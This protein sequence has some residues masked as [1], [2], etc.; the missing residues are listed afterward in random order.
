MGFV[1]DLLGMGG[2]SGTQ[3]R[4][5]PVD[6][7]QGVNQGQINQAYGQTQQGLANQ[8][9]FI[10]ALMG[11]NAVGR[12]GDVFAQQQALASQLGNLASGKGPNPAMAQLAN[13]TGQNV[14][15]QA[16]LAAGQRG[17]N[18]NVGLLARQ[19]G[20]QGANIQQQAV[21]QGAAL[22]AQQQIAA[23]NAL[24]N[25]Q[26]QMGNLATNQAQMQGQALNA[27]NQAS[28]SQ[29]QNLLN[30]LAQYNQTRVGQQNAITAAN[31]GIAG[32]TAQGQ[33]GL[34][35]GVLG[36]VGGFLGLAKGGEVP[37][38]QYMADGGLMMPSAPPPS[39]GN[40]QL[41][42]SGPKSMQGRFLFSSAQAPAP[43]EPEMSVQKG[44]GEMAKSPL[45]QGMS[46]LISTG[47]KIGAN[48]AVPGAGMFLSKGA[49]VPGQAATKGDSLKNDK[50][51]AMLSPKE[52]V[53]PR[54]VTLSKNAPDK[55]KMFV[56]AVL[57]KNGMRKKK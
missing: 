15:N 45:Q 41:D 16:A 9:A 19:I 1:G 10:N 44:M 50:V 56:E 57:A 53:L 7:L 6:V 38:A 43:K 42:V 40:M 33:Q 12:Q 51:P 35:G 31:A 29:Q 46:K 22:G 28:Q 49:M 21:G 39:L 24:A 13:T 30:A 34:L 4:A 8:Q 54:S 55:A 5:S 32:T 2:S 26:A 23:M 27:Y 52:I 20:Q 18:Q 37:E 36:G 17:A 48:A 25:Q 11:Q 3:F 14:A 47:L